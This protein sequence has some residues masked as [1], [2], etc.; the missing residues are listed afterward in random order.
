MNSADSWN[1]HRIEGY[2]FVRLPEEPGYHQVEVNTWRPKAS[3]DAEISSFFLGGSVR[4]KKLEELVR[5]QFIDSNGYS[6]IVNRF[7]LET[8]DAG[9]VKVNINVCHQN[10]KSRKQR[11]QQ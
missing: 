9:K 4:I 8:E 7:G 3:M 6:D 10:Q 1:R 5:T 11:R 2:G